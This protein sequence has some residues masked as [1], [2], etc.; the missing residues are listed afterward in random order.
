MTQINVSNNA[1]AEFCRKHH[2]CKLGFFGSVLRDD[3]TPRSDIDVL[4][5]FDPRHIPGLEFFTMREELAAILGREVDLH[6]AASLSRY[7][8]DQV[9][10]EAETI[11][12]QA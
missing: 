1:I 6:T 9:L 8:R 4:V 7:F 3:F 12:E 10:A 11:Y 2:I 5:D